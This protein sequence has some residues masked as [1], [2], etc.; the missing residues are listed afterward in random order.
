MLQHVQLMLQVVNTMGQAVLINH[1]ELVLYTHLKELQ[2]QL[3]HRFVMLWLIAQMQ[4][5]HI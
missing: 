3:R 5:A 1:Q 4:D 2:I